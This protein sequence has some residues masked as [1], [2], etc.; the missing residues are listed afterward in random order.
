MLTVAAAI[1]LVIGV[2]QD[3]SPQ[4]PPSEPRVGWYVRKF[5]LNIY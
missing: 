2:W 5:K 4:H 3:Y 1:S